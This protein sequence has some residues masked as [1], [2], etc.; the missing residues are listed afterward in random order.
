MEKRKLKP[1]SE[2]K[3]KEL[4]KMRTLA[5]EVS[6]RTGYTTKD[7]TEVWRVGI[8]VIIEYLKDEKSVILPK[9]GMLFASIKPS[10]KVTNMNGGVGFPES[11]VMAARWVIRFRPGIFIKKDLMNK[12]VTKEQID[13]LYED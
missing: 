4:I 11:M 13:N 5:R 2:R 6:R 9:V 1:L 12:E 8:D 7:V 3:P 10:R